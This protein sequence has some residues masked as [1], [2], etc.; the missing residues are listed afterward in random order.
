MAKKTRSTP[1]KKTTAKK[2]SAHATALEA[3]A[4][5]LG[6]HTKELTRNSAA[7]AAHTATVHH[8]NARLLVYSVLNEPLTLSDTTQLSKLGLDFQAL[9]GTAAAIRA[10]GVN[11]DTGLVQACKTIAD[12]VK[13]VAAAAQS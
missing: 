13:V 1:V 3:N 10:R 7:L 2:K 4:V 6:Q 5:A 12:I 8:I 9:A 11:V